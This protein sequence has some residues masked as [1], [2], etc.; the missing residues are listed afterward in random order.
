MSA[1]TVVCGD[2]LE[3]LRDLPEASVDL[4]LFSPPYDDIR[5]ER[6]MDMAYFRALGWALE[7]VTKDGGWA[8]VVIANASREL[9]STLTWQRLCVDWVDLRGWS[10]LQE[11]IYH[12]HGR[13]GGWNKR[14][15]RPDHEVILPFFKGERF[16][17]FDKEALYVSAK[18]AGKVWHGTQRHSDGTLSAIKPTKQA[19]TKCRGTVW[20]IP[21]SNTEGDRAKM[22]HHSTFPRRL[23]SDLVRCFSRP[24][25]LVLD[26]M[27]GSG[28]SLL[29]AQDSG[30]HYLGIDI[31]QKWVDLSLQRLGR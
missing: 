9:R 27:C 24:G 12:R 1:D 5:S 10:L 3:V 15:F 18:H 29:A 19:A 20:T 11:L 2:A 13:P 21:S 31:E 8:V 26:P 16:T 25:D 4:A 28:T 17:T 23:A 7:R 6:P 14:R 30:R 22:A